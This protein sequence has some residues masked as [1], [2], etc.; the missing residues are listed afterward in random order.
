MQ[1]ELARRTA[2]PYHGLASLPDPILASTFLQLLTVP[3][4]AASLAQTC[5]ACALAFFNQRS[6]FVQQRC[7]DLRPHCAFYRCGCSEHVTLDVTWVDQSA[8]RQLSVLPCQPEAFEALWEALFAKLIWP[9]IVNPA[10]Y[11]GSSFRVACV[12]VRLNQPNP[13][14]VSGNDWTEQLVKSADAALHRSFATKNFLCSL[15]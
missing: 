4:T 5:C 15:T 6:A 3:K 11:M 8:V 10:Q 1:L 12:T 9:A 7:W 2:Q 14:I 13:V